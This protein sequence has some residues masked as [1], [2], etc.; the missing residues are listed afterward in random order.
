MPTP[1]SGHEISL[2]MNESPGSSLGSLFDVRCPTAPSNRIMVLTAGYGEGHNAAA[3]ALAAAW[4]DLHGEGTARVVDLF[5][6]ASPRLNVVVRRGY[7][8][9]I[10]RTPKL[11][12]RAYAWMDRST[13]LPRCLGILRRDR[14]LLA[15]LIASTGPRAICSTYPVY[16]FLLE[17]LRR[18]GRLSVPHYNIVTDSIS[19]NSLWWKAGCDGWFLPNEDSAEVMRQ[20]GVDSGRLHVS[21]FPVTLYFS[22]HANEF[23]PPDLAAGAAPRVLYIINTGTRHAEATARLLLAESAWDITCAVGRDDRLRRRLERIAA[24]RSRPATILGWTDAIPRLLMTHHAVVS[25]AGGATTQEAIAARCP[26]IVNQVVPGQEEGNYELLR[27]H[28]AGTLAETPETVLAALRAAFADGGRGW[29]A[30]RSALVSL[31]RPDAARTIATQLLPV[32]A[33]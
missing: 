4:D 30:W 6:L 18:E 13:L 1:R 9:A 14:Q 31:S 7:L 2:E 29:S 12:S 3:R 26:M 20:A 21:G 16:A 10:N 28:Q 22:R 25:K 15:A 8:Y 5:A 27:R 11:W 32:A 17:R 24:G 33:E 19:I 23:A